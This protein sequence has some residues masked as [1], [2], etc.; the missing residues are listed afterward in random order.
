MRP[1]GDIT[2]RKFIVE[3]AQWDDLRVSASGTRLPA[4]NAPTLTKN[5]DNGAGSVGIYQLN[6][7]AINRND[8]FVEFQTPH[9]R[10]PESDMNLHFHWIPLTNNGGNILW[11]CELALSNLNNTFAVTATGV[12]QVT[13]VNAGALLNQNV[14]TPL[15]TISGQGVGMSAFITARLSR[16]A[17]NGADTYTGEAALLGVDL[18]YRIDTLGSQEIV[19][20][21]IP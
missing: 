16:M 6:F 5:M 18:H 2:V 11:E 10:Y 19:N 8:I 9:N 7:S 13:T 15:T 21:F 1:L 17:A 20:K 3:P 12:L 14:H 4:A